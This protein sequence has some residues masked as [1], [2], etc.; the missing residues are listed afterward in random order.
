MPNMCQKLI[1][2]I[3]PNFIYSENPINRLKPINNNQKQLYKKDVQYL[4]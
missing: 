1:D 3:E 2:I 4:R